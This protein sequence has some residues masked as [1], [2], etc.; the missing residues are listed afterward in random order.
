MANKLEELVK[1]ENRTIC[2][3][4]IVSV[5]FALLPCLK[6]VHYALTIPSAIIL[7]SFAAELSLRK[8]LRK[9]VRELDK[10]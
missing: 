4:I 9:R 8:Y 3:C 7:M 5:F 1:L 2:V 6:V 10:S